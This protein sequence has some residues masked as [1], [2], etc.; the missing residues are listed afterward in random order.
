M[1]GNAD[2]GAMT[3]VNIDSETGISAD[4]ATVSTNEVGVAQTLIRTEIPENPDAPVPDDVAPAPWETTLLEYVNNT[5]GQSFEG[6]PSDGLCSITVYTDVETKKTAQTLPIMLTGEPVIGFDTQ[7]FAVENGGSHTIGVLV[8]DKN[9][10]PLTAG[11]KVVISSDAG[12]LEGKTFHNY[13]DGNTIG[14]DQAGQLAR[15][16]YP[17]VISDGREN[18]DNPPVPTTITV[19][20]EW[21]G[22]R[23]RSQ[24][25]GTVD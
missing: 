2:A 13:K 14:P 18:E 4:S 24:I 12:T 22:V 19:T 7:S 10:N 15:I 5:Y 1:I 17:I 21:E 25:K 16:E 6:N 8:S 11:S 9:L 20:V 23:Y 3:Q